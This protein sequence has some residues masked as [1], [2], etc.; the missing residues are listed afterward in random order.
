MSSRYR[1][2]QSTAVALVLVS[3]CYDPIDVI[4]APSLDTTTIDLFDDGEVADD[5]SGDES[6]GPEGADAFDDADGDDDS[7]M[8]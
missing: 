4:P 3:G 8:D 6:A 1:W 2:I 7:R 5:D